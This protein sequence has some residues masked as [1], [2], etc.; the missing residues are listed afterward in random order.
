MDVCGE[1]FSCT[2]AQGHQQEQGKDDLPQKENPLCLV[3]L[4]T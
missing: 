1:T 3:V 4:S 2:A